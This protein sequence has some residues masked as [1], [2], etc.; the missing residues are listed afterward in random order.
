MTETDTRQWIQ[1]TTDSHHRQAK[2]YETFDRV[3]H[4]TSALDDTP[5]TTHDVEA[6]NMN[7]TRRTRQTNITE[8]NRWQLQRNSTGAHDNSHMTNA[9]D[10]EAGKRCRRRKRQGQQGLG[11]C[12]GELCLTKHCR[13]RTQREP[14]QATAT[15]SNGG[16]WSN[17]KT[18][19][20]GPSVLRA[21]L[22]SWR[23]QHPGVADPHNDICEVC[24]LGGRL[25][26]CENCNC[27]W[28]DGCHQRLPCSREHPFY[29]EQ[30]IEEDNAQRDLE[31]LQHLRA[32]PAVPV[33]QR[34]TPVGADR[35]GAA[36]QEC[37][38]STK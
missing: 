9:S 10:K 3:Q 16:V 33:E 24:G 27:V 2:I 23:S 5:K 15:R 29:C 25:T 7:R 17:T 13:R 14:T 1:E 32:A 28:H 35:E 31:G 12:E 26:G 4:E 38:V 11:N 20:H 21:I 37:A 34:N 18:R 6:A 8:M 30:C 19:P 36:F 22:P